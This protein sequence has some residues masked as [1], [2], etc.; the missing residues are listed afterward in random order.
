MLGA[1]TSVQRQTRPADEIVLVIDHNPALYR[2]ALG[3]ISGVKVIENQELRGLSGARNT[4][5]AN[6]NAHIIAFMDEDAVASSNW[7]ESLLGGYTG[8]NVLGVGG[9]VRPLWE[10]GM[11]GWFPEEFQWV[12]G[13][14]YKG[15]PQVKSPVRNP[16]GCNMSFRREALL[17]AGGF[18]NGMGRI[19]SL[20]VGCEETEIS[21]RMRQIHPEAAILYQPEAVVY[22]RVPARRESLSYFARRCYAE[23]L[24]KAQV[25]QFVGSGD[26]LS[27]ERSYVA[28]TLPMGMVRG[29]KDSILT[30]DL[31]GVKRAGLIG[32]GL[33][34]TTAGYLVGAARRIYSR[35]RPALYPSRILFQPAVTDQPVVASPTD[36]GNPPEK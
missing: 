5:I 1:I 18:R 16:I 19:G 13:C 35:P 2:Q 24:S 3:A 10:A 22:H 20:P 31:N 29:I 6:T 21:I 27:S 33:A 25:T 11:P 30:G 17:A 36:R 23:G 32:L 14:S 26:G 15:L 7:I 34:L 9:E 4:G 12:V 28:A 8:T